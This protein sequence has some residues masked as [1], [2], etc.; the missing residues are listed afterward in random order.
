MSGHADPAPVA[1]VVDDDAA[2]RRVLAIHLRAHGWVPLLARDGDEAVELALGA[3]PDV[4]LLDLGLPDLDG[5]E[6]IRRIRASST[7]PIVV[8]SARQAGADKV[9]ALDLG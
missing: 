5:L 8:L 3:G 9:D 2:L 6:V 4:V 7:L 1:L